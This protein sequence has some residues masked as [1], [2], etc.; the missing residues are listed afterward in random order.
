MLKDLKNITKHTGVY[1]LANI[2]TKLLGLFLIPLYTTPKYLSHND[3]GALSV[4][5]A[6]LQLLVGVLTMAMI[7]GLN[8]WYW[9]DKYKSKQKS[10]F[11]TTLA[12][13][14]ICIVPIITGLSLQSD[15]LSIVIFKSTTYSY[16]LKLAVIT[17]GL[18]IINNQILG[19][20]KLKSKSTF[21]SIVSTVKFTLTLL[22][23]LWGIIYKGK[24]LDA[25]WEASLIGECITLLLL[26]PFAK[27][28]IHLHFEYAIL[29][30]I[31]VYGL[32]LMLASLSGVI[33]VTADRYMLSSMSGLENT[34]IYSLGFRFANTLKV[35]IT[36]SIT[37]GLLPIRMKKMN[38]E[39]NQRFFAKINTYTLFVFIFLLL[40]LSL[41]SL[42]ALKLVTGSDTYW[43]AN[44]IIPI[45]GFALFFGLLKNNTT[46]G[47][48]IVKKTKIIGMLIFITSLINIGLNYILIPIWDIYGASF[49]TLFSQVFFCVG[50]TVAAQ[51]NYP[52]PYE[53]RKIILMISISIVIILISHQ[54]IE[55][56]LGARLLIKS[57]L[58]VSFPFILYFFNFYEAVEI[59]NIK[60]A[61]SNWSNPTKLKENINRLISGS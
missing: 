7:S 19:L 40:G 15:Q 13:L 50:I 30:N 33:L 12:F 1:A 34:G 22:L 37:S 28:N 11:F 14:F 61:I 44:G 5:E 23:I 25:I 9:D 2:L 17:A 36:A 45:I 60:K 59:K 55:F 48:V 21:Y 56:S 4:L 32:P 57:L 42:E 20:V 26:I 24:G 35:V 3:F 39:N 18:Q 6:T 51:K 10:I 43:Q 58:F 27:K 31:F 52:I 38:E 53:W 8:R 46:I 49:A 16:L 54:L 29:K 47:L 41:F